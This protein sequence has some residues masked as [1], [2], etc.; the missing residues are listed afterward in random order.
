MKKHFYSNGKLLLTSEYLVLD[1]A[2]ALAIPTVYGQDLMVSTTEKDGI[3]WTSK[4][5]EGAVWFEAAFKIN[6]KLTIKSSTD[7]KIAETLLD[8][9]LSAKKLNEAFLSGSSGFE[10]VTTMNFPREWGLGTSSTLINNCAQWAEVNA[11]KLLEK[12]F[13]GSGYDIACAQS[14]VPLVYS[15]SQQP[16]KF[17]K[18][19][20]N[21]NFTEELYFVYLNK[22]Q[23]SKKAIA[24]YNALSENKEALIQD[25]NKLTEAFINC[26]TLSQFES[27]IERHENLL[28]GLLK[29]PKI[30]ESL[31]SDYNGSVKSLGAW[32]GDFILATGKQA[33]LYFEE[34]G[35][36]TIIPFKKMLK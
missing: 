2:E 20:L 21:W 7:Q 22:K 34:K 11:F 36:T 15:N 17:Q 24:H 13:R 31:F 14:D 25:A 6:P 9:L 3:N 28:S 19:N 30:K 18:L 32:G 4:N 12:S 29:I 26:A 33:P 8:I 1:G 10:V 27:L 5:E 35:Y 23:D 16:P